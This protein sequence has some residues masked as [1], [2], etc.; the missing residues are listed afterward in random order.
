MEEMKEAIHLIQMYTLSKT[1]MCC[2]GKTSG[3]QTLNDFHNCP[4]LNLDL[5]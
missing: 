4:P 2:K 1:K 5:P 3:W